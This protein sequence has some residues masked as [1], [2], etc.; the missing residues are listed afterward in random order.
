MVRLS[1]CRGRTFFSLTVAWACTLSLWL[2]SLAAPVRADD[3]GASGSD[4]GSTGILVNADSSITISLNTLTVNQLTP[5]TIAIQ[6]SDLT[7]FSTLNNQLNLTGQG[8]TSSGC[9]LYMGSCVTWNTP[10]YPTPTSGVIDLAS[11]GSGSL[12][13]SVTLSGSLTLNGSLQLAS[14]NFG[15]GGSGTHQLLNFFTSTQGGVVTLTTN[16]GTVI[17]MTV[18]TG[19][20]VAKHTYA[21]DANLDGMV[22]G[23]DLAAWAVNFTGPLGLSPTADPAKTWTQGDWNFDGSVDGLDAAIWASNYMGTLGGGGLAGLVVDAPGANPTAVVI[24]EGMGITV[25]PEP[26]SLVMLSLA[27]VG[28]LGQ[29]CR[30]TPR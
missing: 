25:V 26:A 10:W 3:P 18:S 22:D 23:R 15:F 16:T 29:R 14:T 9:T 7:G 21:G 30:R 8:T 4:D 27:G 12:S 5:F 20:V 1:G 19:D 24:L 28:L 17:A 6:P 13:D 11:G 2:G